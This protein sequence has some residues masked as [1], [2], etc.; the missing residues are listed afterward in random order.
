MPTMFSFTP[1]KQSPIRPPI[2]P[3]CLMRMLLV[4]LD[5]EVSES[6]IHTFACEKCQHREGRV[7]KVQKRD[8]TVRHK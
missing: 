8:L 1:S 4:E 5:T 3:K 2:C 7:I 6:E